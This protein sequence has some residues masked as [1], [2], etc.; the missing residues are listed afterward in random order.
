MD[1]SSKSSGSGSGGE[2]AYSETNNQVEGVD[3]SDIVKTDG[4]FIYS[5][6]NGR[7]I[8]TD[9]RKPSAN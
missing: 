6:V 9:I 3:E 7:V 1:S 5:I 8:I 4:E 2:L